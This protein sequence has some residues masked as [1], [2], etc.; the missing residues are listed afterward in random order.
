MFKD[1]SLQSGFFSVHSSSV[2]VLFFCVLF[3]FLSFLER[4]CFCF[5][6]LESSCIRSECNK[7][8]E[9]KPLV[10]LFLGSK[11]R[12]FC[13]QKLHHFYKL[14][15]QFLLTQCFK[16]FIFTTLFQGD[17]SGKGSNYSCGRSV[18][19]VCLSV[20]IVYDLGTFLIPEFVIQIDFDFSHYV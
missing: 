10:S 8:L 3:V 9:L 12:H 1:T 2:V 18:S 5:Y 20:W 15:F 7:Y 14:R 19:V 16:W 11:I 13:F 6:N 4:C 17:C